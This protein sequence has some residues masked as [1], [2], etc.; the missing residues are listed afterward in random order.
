[1]MFS[2]CA[3]LV[4]DRLTRASA[5]QTRQHIDIGAVDVEKL[6]GK[7]GFVSSFRQND[8]TTTTEADWS[9]WH[10]DSCVLLELPG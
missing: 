3:A 4:F 5:L 2:V 10:K 9:M 8:L 6:T 1:M 7:T